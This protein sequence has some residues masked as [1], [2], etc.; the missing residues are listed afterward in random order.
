MIW[1]AIIGQ[2]EAVARLRRGA[3]GGRLAHAYLVTGPPGVGKRLLAR[4]FATALL[5]ESC[6]EGELDACGRCNSCRM[7]RAGMHPDF[8]H[9]ACPE[10][11]SELPI[12]LLVGSL[13]KRGREGLCHD[14]SLRPM[15]SRRRVAVIEDA[16]RMSAESANALLKTLEE[17]PA[18]AVLVLIAADAGSILPTIRSRCQ[19][20]RLQP[21]PASDVA[22]LILDRE[23]AGSKAEA[24]AA[25]ALAGGSLEVA[26]QLLDPQLRAVR[27]TIFETLASPRPKMHALARAALEALEAAGGDSQRQRTFAQWIVGFLVDFFRTAL[28][29]WSGAAETPGETP[30]AGRE[31]IAGFLRRFPVEDPASA[32]ALGEA[33]DRSVDAEQQLASNVATT[34]CLEALFSDLGRI[35]QLQAVR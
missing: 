22:R 15:V 31:Q 6:S 9:L 17:P 24:E 23:W 12:E 21:L 4:L 2:D 20:I 25:A 11:K 30:P 27:A 33:L 35:L 1:D 10:G 29:Q 8:L 19:M 34:L 26:Q 32:D 16:D 3:A 5:C 18:Y 7:M 28:R 14:L 13:D